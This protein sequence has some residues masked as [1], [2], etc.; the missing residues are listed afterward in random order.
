MVQDP[1]N[2]ETVFA[3]RD[4][5]S[6]V[7]FSGCSHQGIENIMAAA[8]ERFPD[9]PVRAMFGGFHMSSPATG[10]LSEPESSVRETAERLLSY[11]GCRYY[12]GHCTGALAYSLMKETMGE[13]IELLAAGAVL[14][15]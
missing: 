15:V 1:F 13:R 14:D 2:H 5:G 12:T 6:L 11:G 4:Q 7:V 9:T 8:A 3:I 10:K